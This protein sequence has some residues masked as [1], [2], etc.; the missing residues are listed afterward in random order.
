MSRARDRRKKREREAWVK[1]KGGQYAQA[2][3][4]A[5]FPVVVCNECHGSGR[6]ANWREFGSDGAVG[7]GGRYEMCRKCGG[8][9]KVRAGTSHINVTI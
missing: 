6:A 1:R 2:R 7:L 3:M 9:G 8:D 5:M 4:R